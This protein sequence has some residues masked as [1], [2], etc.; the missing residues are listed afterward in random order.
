[1]ESARCHRH[2]WL[3]ASLAAILACAA[4]PFPAHAAEAGPLVIETI[5][6]AATSQIAE[7][8]SAPGAAFAPG[9]PS[10]PSANAMPAATSAAGADA[11]PSAPAAADAAPETSEA[12]Y[13]LGGLQF[14][15]P[16]GFR[17]VALG[18]LALAAN[19]DGTLV[20][21]AASVPAVADADDASLLAADPEAFFWAVAQDAAGQLDAE[22]V[23][24]GAYELADG[25]VSYFYGTVST[26]DGDEVLTTSCFVPLNDGFTL[27]QIT[28][29]TSDEDLVEQAD[30]ISASIVLTT[31]DAAPLDRQ[32]DVE[33]AQQVEV[34][35]VTLGLPA[36]FATNDATESATPSWSNADGTVAFT[37]LP[38]LVNDVAAIGEESL[39][40]IA[41]GV[42][43]QL[44]GQTL[45][46]A[47]LDN[48]GTGVRVCLFSF[49]DS[50]SGYMGILG[51]TVVA[52][53]S[54]TGFLAVAPASCPEK[55]A[56][57]VATVFASIRMVS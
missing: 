15:V 20:V 17:V 30:Q 52:D 22:P 57:A 50:G 2:V 54:A 56:D 49:E 16:A 35:G 27:V 55:T 28:V 42:V 5:R 29:D 26:V 40:S 4:A 3:V 47:F 41:E 25:T 44:G 18:D 23:A 34:G 33:L 39:G 53:G 9:A 11:T 24:L 13:A 38:S 51:A 10:A 37:V 8:A 48:D 7:S 36:D 12:T 46:T 32:P 6:S 45:G 19:A 1:M 31:D 21:S 14:T 43:Q